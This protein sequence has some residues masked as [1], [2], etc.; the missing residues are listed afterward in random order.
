LIGIVVRITVAIMIAWFR[1]LAVLHGEDVAV[2]VYAVADVGRSRKDLSVVRNTVSFTLRDTVPIFVYRIAGVAAFIDV[3]IAI[4]V[5]PIAS[6]VAPTVLSGTWIDVRVV[7]V[8][9]HIFRPLCA[10]A[11]AVRI[12]VE[13]FVDVSVTVIVDPIAQ[14]I[15]AREDVAV[16]VVAIHAFVGAVEVIIYVAITVGTALVDAP[17]AVVVDTVAAQLESTR[18]YVAV[19]VVTVPVV[20]GL[21][22][23]DPTALRPWRPLPVPIAI[24]I[25]EPCQQQ[26]LVGLAITVVVLGVADRL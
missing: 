25:H 9:V 17:I 13:I 26:P 20:F 24:T 15:V 23:T 3:P 5:H 11:P 21:A 6:A 8:A 16:G 19:T 1:H 14:L 22:H 10:D 18:V 2:V 12:H 7:I 4:V